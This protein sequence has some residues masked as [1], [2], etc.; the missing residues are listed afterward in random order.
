M[1]HTLT[2]DQKGRIKLPWQIMESF[3]IK[4]DSEFIVEMTE[5]GLLLKPKPKSTAA[6]LTER[7]ST[8]NLPVADWE[9]ME[10]EI[11]AGRIDS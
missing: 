3:G 10:E 6:P 11:N 5:F 9:Q 8:M 1:A 7:L 2:I 4:A